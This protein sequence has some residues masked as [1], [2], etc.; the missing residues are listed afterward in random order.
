VKPRV[1]YW[2]NIPAP[3]MVERFNAVAGRANLDF[4]AW[5]SM[6]TEKDRS[7]RVDESSWEFQYKY[8]PQL[9]ARYPLVLPSPLVRGRVPDALVSL[10]AAPSFMLGW[11]IAR[12]RGAR[13]AFWVEVTFD[14]LVTRRRWKESVKSLVFPRADGI[15]TAGRDGREFALRYGVSPDRVFIVPHVID[16][17]HYARGSASARSSRERVRAELG[18]RGVTFVYVGR[19]WLGKG[20]QYLLDA[21]GTLQRT[22]ASEVSL[23]LVG[24][25]VDEGLLRARCREERLAN[26][27]FTGFR[28]ADSLPRLYAAA[29]VFVFPALGDTFG[30]V[31]PEAMAC[32]L[33]VIATSAS[34]EID[35]R[36]TD[37]VNGYIV[38][39]ADGEALRDRMARLADDGER[40]KTMG[41]A[42]REKVAGQT[43]HVWAQ[44]F[45]NAIDV[46]L[47]MPRSADAR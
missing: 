6:K 5:F 3:Y 11:T 35:D 33:P 47:T 19:L 10:Y 29:D 23:L 18:V 9:T 17:D 39:P 1:V 34:G 4:E 43:P 40:R 8:L 16:F 27:V 2:N 13:T 36:V 24:D 37:G 21:F 38:P 12:T 7:W 26:V 31:V 25:G 28:D 14:A 30:M 41:A 15:L 32:G 20:L 46:I 22:T 45:E 44:A 42:A